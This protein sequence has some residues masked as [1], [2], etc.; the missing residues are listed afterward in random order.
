MISLQIMFIYY[1]LSIYTV[2]VAQS[3]EP[4]VSQNGYGHAYVQ[5]SVELE[6]VNCVRDMTMVPTHVSEA[7]IPIHPS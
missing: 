4:S 2:D 7:L 3:C 5:G 1:L 6:H